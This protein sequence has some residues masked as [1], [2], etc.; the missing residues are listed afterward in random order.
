MAVYNARPEL[1]TEVQ[2]KADGSPVTQ[3]DLAAH[4]VI[5]RGLAALTP[6]IPVVSEEDSASQA[7]RQLHG[8]FWLVEPLDGT[9]EFLARNGEFTVNIALI[10][11]GRPVLGVV[12]APALALAYSGAA[13]LGAFRDAGQ[14][15]VPIRVA[16]PAATTGQR[17]R[18]LASKSHLNA[19]TQ[20][21]LR[22]LGPHELLRAVR[23]SSAALPKAVPTSTRAWAPPANGTPPPPRPCWRQ[24]AAACL[25]STGSRCATASRR[26][27]T[28]TSWRR[29]RPLAQASA[30]RPP[31]S[32]APALTPGRSGLRTAR[33]R[34]L[35]GKPPSAPR[36]AP[37][38]PCRGSPGNA[39]PRSG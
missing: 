33:C 19:E 27:S 30:W 38:S 13:G 22:Q 3:A 24:P 20:A 29:Q 16:T 28:P 23:S 36:S 12:V 18:V 14:G 4:R 9:K 2:H 25:S 6:D 17:L 1:A 26:C 34:L 8:R 35:P 39:A 7:H 21:F 5:A 31:P 37:A 11:E 32:R 10:Q 15:P